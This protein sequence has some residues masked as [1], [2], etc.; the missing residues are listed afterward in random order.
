MPE[1][2]VTILPKLQSTEVFCNAPKYDFRLE[3]ALNRC[4]VGHRNMQYR[5]KS[6]FRPVVGDTVGPFMASSGL[7]DVES[8]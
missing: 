4:F 8:V 5:Q 6:P 3:I 1:A 7:Q 2:A